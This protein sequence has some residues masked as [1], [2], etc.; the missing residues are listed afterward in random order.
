MITEISGKVSISENKKK[1]EVTVSN[2]EGESE[3]YLIPFA[4]A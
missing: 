3:T 2:D 1:R 4:V